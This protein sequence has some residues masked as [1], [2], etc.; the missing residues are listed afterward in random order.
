LAWKVE[1]S[2]HADKQLDK[3]SKAD[4]QRVVKTLRQIATLNNPRERG[5]ALVGDRAG[6]WRYRIGDYRVIAKIEDGRM[7]IVIIAVGHR[8]EVYR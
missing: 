7:I 6:Y 4:Q 5:H 3:L 1:F 2:R 8:R